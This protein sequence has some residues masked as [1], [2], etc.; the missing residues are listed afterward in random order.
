MYKKGARRQVSIIF[1]TH[2]NYQ[3]LFCK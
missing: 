3:Q 2:Q 1:W